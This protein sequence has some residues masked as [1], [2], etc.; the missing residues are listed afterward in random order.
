M[1]TDEMLQRLAPGAHRE[2]QDS[3]FDRTGSKMCAV[4]LTSGT[5]FRGDLE[6][7][8]AV[9]GTG[10][11]D[12][13]WQSQQCA[14]FKGRPSAAGPG[15]V[16]CFVVRQWSDGQARLDGQAWIGD[17]YQVKVAYQL[18]EP[19]QFPAGAERDLRALLAAGIDALSR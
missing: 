7:T 11:F 6:V 15:D 17:D 5:A 2:H 9:D 16:S 13:K 4:D 10:I 1:I 3:L 12:A 8:Y 18:V 19:M 14:Y